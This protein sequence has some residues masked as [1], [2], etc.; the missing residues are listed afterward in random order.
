MKQSRLLSTSHFQQKYWNTKATVIILLLVFSVTTSFATN[1]G[2]EPDSSFFSHWLDNV[3]KTQEVQPHWAPLLSMPSPRL[4]QGLRYNY[5]QQYFPNSSTLTNYGMGKGLELILGEN[6][7][8]QI[9]IPAYLDRETAKAAT[10]G[11]ADETF[12]SRFRFM[13]ANEENGNYIV[14][15]SFGLSIPTGSDQFSSHNTILTPTFAAG[16]GWGTRQ[17]G[18]NIQSSLSASV[19]DN[20]LSTTGIPLSWVFALQAQILQK[21][22]PEIEANYTH[23]CKGA[24]DGR[25]QL[26][27]TYGINF[28]RFEINDREKIT[29]GIGYQ[30]PRWANF[31][32]FS[33]GWISTVKLSF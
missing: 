30:E 18:I 11:W 5:N 22:W 15:G 23:W 20:N 2:S 29:F 14:S 4:T 32:T 10:S 17:Y 9:G 12:L 13:A 6:V 27:L 28:G 25:E 19:P 7:E 24:Y 16:K 33:R 1:E 8:V 21:F 3:T 26:V 31:S